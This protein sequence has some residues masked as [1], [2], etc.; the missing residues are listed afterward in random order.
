LLAREG[1]GGLKSIG[2]GG[3]RKMKAQR[4]GELSG[5][6]AGY[7]LMEGGTNGVYAD[8]AISVPGWREERRG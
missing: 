4:K 6:S 5:L 3:I 7:T 2:S 1:K 8:G